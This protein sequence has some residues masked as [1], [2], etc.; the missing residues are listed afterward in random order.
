MEIKT[1]QRQEL[2]LHD[3]S[4]ELLIS[5]SIRGNEMVMSP[6]ELLSLLGSKLAQ[7]SAPGGSS[8]HSGGPNTSSNGFVH[9]NGEGPINASINGNKMKSKVNR[10]TK[11]LDA[12]DHKEAE[13]Q[14][15]PLLQD[16]AKLNQRVSKVQFERLK[17]LL[18]RYEW[19]EDIQKLLP[20]LDKYRGVS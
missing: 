2:N 8:V 5:F 9:P 4:P 16:L 6:K 15:L 12:N 3:L 7:N 18:G 1:R 14:L 19:S 13:S 20:V 11:A 10:I 17:G